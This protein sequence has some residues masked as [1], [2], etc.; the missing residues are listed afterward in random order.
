MSHE[1]EFYKNIIENLYDGIYFVDRDRRITYWNKGAERISGYTAAQ[2]IGRRCRDN[3]LNHVTAN[4]VSLCQDHCPLAAVMQDGKPREAEVYLHH[5]DGY[6]V[7]I[8]VRAT[9][10]HDEEGNIIGAVESFSNNENVINA[11]RRLNEMHQLAR[12]DALTRIG[13]RRHIE[14]RI[15]AAIVE[16][17]DNQS[18][19]GLLF[20]DI[21]H[22]KKINDTYGHDTGDLA[23]CMIA[24]TFRLALRVTD[25]VGR[26]GGEEFVAILHDISSEQALSAAAEKVRTLIEASRLDLDGESLTV[27]ASIGATLLYSNDTPEGIVRR[28][29]GLMY[30]SKQ[31]GGNRVTVG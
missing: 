6:R 23:L 18:M 1:T 8:I 13:N 11:R 24:N 9:A 19:V 7:P 10:L 14:G 29:D 26:W 30:R 25:T 27:T 20:M 12:T 5:A 2:V 22:F 31:A 21:D 15:R 17:E 28:A 4:G 3:L 16:F